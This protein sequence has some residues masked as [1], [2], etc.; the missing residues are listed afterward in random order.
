VARLRRLAADLGPSETVSLKMV[1]ESDL[2]RLR[3]APDDPLRELVRLAN[4]MS[5]E[6]A[7]MRRSLLP[8]LLRAAARNQAHQRPA[9]ALFE[10]GPTYAPRPDG[11]AEERAWLAALLFGAPERAHWRAAPAPVDLFA[12]TG[13]AEALG[14]GVRVR[15]SAAPGAA[16]PYGH[17]VRQ[18]V[19]RAGG[20]DVG[21]A[22]EIHPLVLREFDVRGPAAA[23]VLDLPALL[24]ARPAAP[25]FADLL[26]VPV[27]TRDL[28]VVVGEDARAAD[29][30]AAAL[31]A[32]GPLV[33][34]A[35]VF[36]RYAGAPV[37]DGKVS[38]ALRL[39][40]ADPG[41]TLTDEE[42]EGAVDAVVRALREGF[43]AELRA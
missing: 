20:A 38:L 22:G 19:L 15:V 42:I 18:A 21:W 25:Q 4:P 9:G 30:A 29:L 14:R 39:S 40:I 23:L 7:V 24:A 2:D 3:V 34:D 12:A 36:D 31:G 32:G 11:L 33:R 13:L 43:G 17:P 6:M 8:G 37:P 5:E 35:V 41:R 27:S 16:A 28:A 26:S 1:P 10:I